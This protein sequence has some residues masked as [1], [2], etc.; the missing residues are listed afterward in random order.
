MILKGVESASF[1]NIIITITKLVPL[2]LFILIMIVSFKMNVFTSDF[3]LTKSGKF[4]FSSVLTQ[5]KSTMLV[6][7]WVFA[8]IEGAVVFFLVVPNIEKI[9]VELQC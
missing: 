8:G 4:E 2:F 9:L 1:V 6:T 7:I 3:W 5:V